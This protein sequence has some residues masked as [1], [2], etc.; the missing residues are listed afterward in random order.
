M[1]FAAR[2]DRVGESVHATLTSGTP[3][4]YIFRGLVLNNKGWI[5]QAGSDLWADLLDT[6]DLRISSVV[7]FWAT[8]HPGDKA[9][10]GAGPAAWYESRIDG[11]LILGVGD[12]VLDGR[13][14][15]YSS[16]N[17][18]FEDIY[19]LRG[20]IAYDDDR[21]FSQG[22]SRAIFR[23]FAPKLT[24]AYEAK[25]ARDQQKSGAYAEVAIAPRLH[26]LEGVALSADLS[27]PISA[28]FSVADYYEFADKNGDIKDHG[29]GFA[30]FGTNLVLAL[31]FVPER[32]GVWTLTGYFDAVLP[33]AQADAAGSKV[34]TVEL[35][36][37]TYGALHF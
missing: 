6:D 21:L 12:L 9:K 25:G 18:S 13:L 34:D 5:G 8:L 26:I 3:N 30:S 28:G 1:P 20:V 27:F 35:L 24:L 17:G 23:G 32:L 10:V 22:S 29:L 15:I 11:G 19:E 2:A 4:Q 37:G 36:V 7:G 31:G 16:P 33:V 14:V